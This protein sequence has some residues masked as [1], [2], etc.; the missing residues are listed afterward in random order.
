VPP[1]HI[2]GI[3]EDEEVNASG[4]INNEE[5]VVVQ[6]LVSVTIMV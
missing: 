5:T 4:S 1:L 3:V 2:E 6:P